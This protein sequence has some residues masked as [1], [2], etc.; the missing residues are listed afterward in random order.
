KSYAT[1]EGWERHRDKIIELYIKKTLKE[2]LEI[3]EHDHNFVATERMYK[4][5]FKDWGIIK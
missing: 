1:P 2:V 4:A 5:R 3:M